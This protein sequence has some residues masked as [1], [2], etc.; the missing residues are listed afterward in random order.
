MWAKTA[1][2]VVIPAE[3]IDCFPDQ[4]EPGDV[5]GGKQHCR[6][7]VDQKLPARPYTRRREPVC[8]PRNPEEEQGRKPARRLPNDR[9]G[10]AECRFLIH[11]R[12]H[13]EDV[14]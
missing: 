2:V 8:Y 4:H 7:Y 3:R 12:D 10:D 14:D 11:P 6:R 9:P 13:A 1:E 5:T